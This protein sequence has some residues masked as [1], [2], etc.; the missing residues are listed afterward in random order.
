MKRILRAGILVATVS[1]LFTGCGSNSLVSGVKGGYEEAAWT[2]KETDPSQEDWTMP[3]ETLPDTYEDNQN[4]KEESKNTS[5]GTAAFK[6]AEGHS[7]ST[8]DMETFEIGN[9]LSDGTFLYYYTTKVG[10]LPLGTQEDNRQVVHCAAA[11]NYKSKM[12]KVFH[13]TKFDRI[14]MD[15]ESFYMQLCSSSG[16]GDIFIYD[17]GVGY[18]YGADG[19]LKFQTDIENFVRKHF[20]GYSVVT[21][22][23]LTDGNNRIYVD[24]TIEKT[25]ISAAPETDPTG[26]DDNTTEEEADKEAEALDK[27]FEDKLIETVLVYDFVEYTG[28]IDQTNIKMDAQIDHWKKL[29][30]SS[31]AYFGWM[32][33]AEDDWE[34]TVSAV[35]AEW[36]PAHLYH[37]TIWDEDQLDKVGISDEYFYGTPVFQWNGD[38]VFGFEADGYVSNFEPDISKY[39]LFT[40]LKADTKLSGLFVKMDD[41]YYELYGKTNDDLDDGGYNSV[42]FKRTV[43]RVDEEKETV[44]DPETNETTEVTN[45]LYSSLTQELTKNRKRD[46]YL[47]NAYLEGYWTLKRG[48]ISSVFD[49]VD[50]NVFAL[51]KEG[52]GDSATEKLALLKRD[53]S[54]KE[55]GTVTG[56][57]F[58]DFFRQDGTDYFSLTFNENSYLYSFDIGSEQIA[59]TGWQS[60]PAQLFTDPIKKVFNMNTE[61]SSEYHNAYGDMVKDSK[62]NTTG[63]SAGEHLDGTNMVQVE[64]KDIQE[65]Y[66]SMISRY[67]QAEIE[68]YSEEKRAELALAMAQTGMNLANTA[69]KGYL[70]CST[71]HGLIYLDRGSKYAYCLDEGTWY[72]VW[73]FGDKIVAVGFGNEAVTYDAIDIA[74]ACVTEFDI[75]TLYVNGLKGIVSSMY[76]VLSNEREDTL[77]DSQKE[78]MKQWNDDNVNRKVEFIAPEDDKNVYDAWKDSVPGE[79]TK[80]RTETTAAGENGEK[81]QDTPKE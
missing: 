74:H 43:N 55:I 28:S 25:A 1:V 47:E 22:E 40:D 12:M 68:S 16:D 34:K 5:N 51:I 37:L 52:S 62:G 46:S 2:V 64:L 31:A 66:L 63:N 70:V 80:E 19:V 44:T 65:E 59:I 7:D 32:P 71:T 20:K 36:G 57:S 27:E 4:A 53:G 78:L 11:Y 39:S 77:T 15:K 76:D 79:L 29:I 6:V 58:I 73:K 17:N 67:L 42:S 45:Y 10:E 24:L 35:P 13:E 41:H 69:G 61:V 26:T 81:F 48:G 49:V 38:P 23:A 75:D 60:L 21:T 3:T 50:G 54:L 18:L 33:S 30:D 8:N 56:A 72:G 14:N 9:L